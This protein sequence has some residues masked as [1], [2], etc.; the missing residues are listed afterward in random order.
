ML[1]TYLVPGA[2]LALLGPG[3]LERYRDALVSLARELNL[4]GAR[5]PGW[6]TQAELAAY[7]RRADLFATMSEHEGVCVPLL[8][9]MSFDVPVLAR[10]FA[11]IPETMGEA[12]L[13]LPPGEDAMLV[14]EALAALL[15]ETA[16]RLELVRRGRARVDDFDAGTARATFLGHL[17][18]V[19]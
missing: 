17:A 13:L 15:G 19:A 4:R 2:N 6:L 11:A 7:Y 3:R 5:I 8:E 18:S 12:G 14:A 10:A 1:T 16:L 9:A